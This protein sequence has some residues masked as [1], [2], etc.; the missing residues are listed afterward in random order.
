M[1]AAGP[2]AELPASRS[3]EE[4]AGK[5]DARPLEVRRRAHL[6]KKFE[7][8]RQREAARAVRWTMLRPTEAKADLPLLTVLDDD[9]VLASGDQT[10]SDT[11]EL[12]FRTDVK[13]ITAIRLEALPDE[14]L[15]CL[16]NDGVLRII[17]L[18]DAQKNIA[19]EKTRLALGL[20]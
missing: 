15:Q 17:A 5:R 8:W 20:Q 12:K 18:A 19:V 2:A 14:R 10:K 3:P 9:S 11:Y 16:G 13:G 7:Q 4:A 1:P 6:E